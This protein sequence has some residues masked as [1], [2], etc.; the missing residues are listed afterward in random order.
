[1]KLVGIREAREHLSDLVHQAQ[2]ERV[3]LTRHGQPAALLVGVAGQDLATV[4]L[5]RD[6]VFWRQLAVQRRRNDTVSE[7]EA[8]RL[9]GL[10][11]RS[12]TKPANRGTESSRSGRPPRST[13]S[14][15][16]GAAD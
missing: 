2:R 12:R 4:L 1:M 9:L 7:A 8:R 16:A 11:Q 10:V 3:V 14:G 5:Q 6:E 13:T 15:P